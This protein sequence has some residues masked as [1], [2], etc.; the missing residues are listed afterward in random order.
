MGQSM[1]GRTHAVRLSVI[2]AVR[3]DEDSV[4]G[5]VRALA[6]RLRARNL[7]FEILAVADGSHDTSLTL[8]RFLCAEL[9][10]LSLLGLARSGRGFRRATAHALGEVVLLWE[11]DRGRRIP[12][13]ILGWALSRLARRAAVVVRGRFV[14]AH[15]LRALSV[16]LET[17][18]RGDEYEAR[19]ER[20]AADLRLDVEIVGRRRKRFPWSP[21]RRILML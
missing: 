8:L 2:V 13:A 5:D 20:K 19:F 15:R 9:P 16:L 6:H 12:H 3:D 11:A 1:P 14:L 21:M 10:E 7:D 17:T 4:C 18:G